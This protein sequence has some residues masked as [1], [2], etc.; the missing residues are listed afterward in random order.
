MAESEAGARVF[1]QAFACGLAGGARVAELVHARVA[2]QVETQVLGGA[3]GVL[4]RSAV[5]AGIEDDEGL[6]VRVGLPGVDLVVPQP[7]AVRDA[8]AGDELPVGRLPVVVARDEHRV[9]V[10]RVVLPA[11]VGVVHAVAGRDDRAAVG[12]VDDRGGAAGR[13]HRDR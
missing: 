11:E 1:G 7:S 10:P 6:V 2:G 13:P 8:G 9:G 12:A 3:D 4:Y 5:G